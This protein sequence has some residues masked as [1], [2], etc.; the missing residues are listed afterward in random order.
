MESKRQLQAGELLKR[1]FGI[2]LQQQGSYIYGQAFVTVTNVKMT[3]DFGL[4]KIYVS[5]YNVEDKN[6]VVRQ[7]ND[8]IHP[9]KSALVHRIKRHVRRIPNIHFY[10]DETLDEMFGINQLF[11][12]LHAEN[13]MGSTE[14]E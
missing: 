9:L 10:M 5:V 1:N 13:K 12:R 11:D 14:E 8:H 4:A 3:P 7:L 6:L 2:V